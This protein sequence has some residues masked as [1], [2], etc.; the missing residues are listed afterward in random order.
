MRP[1]VITLVFAVLLNALANILIK[2]GMTRAG[3]ASGLVS[4]LKHVLRQPAVWG[5][6]VSFA[7]ALGAYS[8]VLT[9]MNLSVAYPIMVSMGLIVVVLASAF[10]LM[11]PI[12]AVQIVGFGLI[13]AGVW[14]VAK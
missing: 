13:I 2:V 10:L 1:G 3:K 4:M 14:L 11:E 7:L 12:S 8:L 6:M 5:G 9:K